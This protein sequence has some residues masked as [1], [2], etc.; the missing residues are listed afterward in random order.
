[1]NKLINIESMNTNNTY[2]LIVHDRSRGA[3]TQVKTIRLVKSCLLFQSL[4]HKGVANDDDDD[5]ERRDAKLTRTTA[6]DAVK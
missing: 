3:H 5:D 2:D 4:T 6:C 1:M